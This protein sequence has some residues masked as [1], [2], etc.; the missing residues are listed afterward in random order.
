MVDLTT[1]GGLTFS[2]NP[3]NVT[4]VTDHDPETGTAVTG[5]Y[6]VIA[7]ML[8]INE[9]AAT[10]MARLGPA[11]KFAKL[12]RPD[13]N[14]FWVAGKAVGYIRPPVPNEYV[15]GVNTVIGLGGFTTPPGVIE[16]PV[17]ARAAINAQGGKL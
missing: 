1:T 8:K 11:A 10:F 2:F 14:P 12:T 6:G 13:G 9:P 17:S 16:S 15:A 5:V 3:E 4:G 7:T